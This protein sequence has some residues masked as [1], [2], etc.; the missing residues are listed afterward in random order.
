MTINYRIEGDGPALLLIHGMG[1]TFTIWQ[2]LAPLL[3]PHYKLIMVELPGNGASPLP[4]ARCHDYY[5]TCA[6]ALEVLRQELNIEQWDILSYSLGTW[7]GQKYL[8]TYPESVKRSIFLC[9]ACVN[10]LWAINLKAL[11]WLDHRMPS[12]GNWLLSGWRL[13]RL[14]LAFGFNGREHPYAA[15]WSREIS[16]QPVEIIK[17]SLR[18]L[19]ET[20]RAPFDLPSKPALFIWGKNDNVTQIPHPLRP[21]DAV[22]PANHSAPML[23]AEEVANLILQFTREYTSNR[24]TSS[25]AAQSS[26]LLPQA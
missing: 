20:G 26:S 2:N 17:T 18:E 5:H 15:L 6:K 25:P 4:D 13:H 12:V 1:V 10:P 23:A 14:V 11:N 24:T 22:I 21:M 7:V 9:P 3:R 8:N 19:P 16:S